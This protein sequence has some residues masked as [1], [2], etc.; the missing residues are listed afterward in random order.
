LYSG[1]DYSEGLRAK[2]DVARYKLHV[3]AK[4][5]GGVVPATQA[6]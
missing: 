4:F 3:D 1:N 2:L 6:N 5:W